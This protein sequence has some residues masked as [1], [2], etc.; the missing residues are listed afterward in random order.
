MIFSFVMFRDDM[1][2]SD[3][4]LLIN[5]AVEMGAKLISATYKYYIGKINED[6]ITTIIGNRSYAG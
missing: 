5:E 1:D 3:F 6:E 2:L 4:D